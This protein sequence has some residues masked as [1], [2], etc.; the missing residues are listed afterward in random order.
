MVLRDVC[1]LPRGAIS[2]RTKRRRLA[3]RRRSPRHG[4]SRAIR[5]PRHGFVV[6]STLD[7]IHNYQSTVDELITALKSPESSGSPSVLSIVERLAQTDERLQSPPACAA[8]RD[9]TAASA[10]R[11][12]RRRRKA[13]GYLLEL[14][15]EMQRAE[16]S[17]RRS[18]SAAREVLE[19][20]DASR[21][22][23]RDAGIEGGDRVRRAHQ[24][25]ERGAGRRRGVDGGS[26]E[27]FRRG[28]GTPAP[29][30][31]MLAA[32]RSAE[33]GKR[34]EGAAAAAGRRRRAAG[35]APPDVRKLRVGTRRCPR[36]R[37]PRAAPPP[38]AAAAAQDD[39]DDD[40][41]SRSS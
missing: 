41:L 15:A 36:S 19:R 37:R 14:A 35:A 25:V 16:S 4:L 13:A 39:D 1:G 5:R 29:Q 3:I 40:D 18:A 26:K 38:A 33:I 12:S 23:G 17:S 7:T 2:L 24:L 31:H 6:A 22:P 11:R 32:S 20:A 28:W 8:A 9:A 21:E 30:Q 10:R 27:G 34:P